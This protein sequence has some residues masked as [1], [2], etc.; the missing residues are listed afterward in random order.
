V[1][2]L[3]PD[4]QVDIAPGAAAALNDDTRGRILDA[5]LEVLRT[6][7]HGQF[8]VQK[9]ARSAGVYQ[10]NVTYY[11][12]RRRGLVLALAVRVVEDYLRTF[13]ERFAA[14]D[15]AGEGWAETFVCWL[16]EDAVSEDRVRLLPELWSMANA[17]PEVAAQV[18]RA[19]DEVTDVVL[20]RLGFTAGTPGGDVLRRAIVLT[21]LAAQGLTAIHGHRAADDPRLVDLRADLCALH[22]PALV[23]ARR[24]AMALVDG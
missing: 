7:G 11:W 2:E 16:V 4:A 10:G 8:S 17:D 9:V 5:G 21:G 13:E 20:G 23:A 12:P 3:P 19:F 18:S 6:V 24:R 22:V 14:F 15:A 1:R